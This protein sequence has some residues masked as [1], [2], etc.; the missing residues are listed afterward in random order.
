[1]KKIK[2]SLKKVIPSSSNTFMARTK[3]LENELKAQKKLMQINQQQNQALLLQIL[4]GLAKEQAQNLERYKINQKII[5]NKFLKFENNCI[6]L[7]SQADGLEEI[8]TTQKQII[9]QFSKQEKFNLELE[10]KFEELSNNFLEI[11]KQL[12][13]QDQALMRQENTIIEKEDLLKRSLTE[14][15]HELKI[16]LATQQE[17][18]FKKQSEFFQPINKEIQKLTQKSEAAKRAAD[19]SVWA[20]IF[21]HTII[22]S[23]WLQDKTFSAGRW[24]IGYP[25]LYAIYRILD[26]I[27]PK[28][29]LEL[30]LGQSTRLVSQY[31]ST[32]DDV[33]HFVVENNGQWINFFEN[34]FALPTNSEIIEL[35]W[36]FKEYKNQNVRVFKDFKETFKEEKFDFICIDAPLGGD[37]K[38]YARIDIL[39]ILPYSTHTYSN[40]N[41]KPRFL[42]ELE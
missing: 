39:E 22:N 4:N 38:K 16:E 19:E 37:M 29:I 14:Y 20:H 11:S 1:M 10:N 3:E 35:S 8:L 31:V 24:A 33:I 12:S 15:K 6:E 27:K 40:S 28:R 7:I 13:T 17:K 2:N 23:T 26:E 30:G 32:Q 34:S 18:E 36:E 5:E 25:V 9:T 42:F 41:R 21:Q